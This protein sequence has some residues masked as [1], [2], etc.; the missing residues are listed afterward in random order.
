MD[1]SE[2]VRTASYHSL[3]LGK[4]RGCRWTG[5]KEAVTGRT[6]D[7]TFDLRGRRSTLYHPANIQGSQFVGNVL[8]LLK[9]LLFRFNG[10]IALRRKL[11]LKQ[12]QCK[13]TAALDNLYW[14]GIFPPLAVFR[15]W[16]VLVLYF[17]GTI[18]SPIQLRLA[19][20][21]I[22]ASIFMMYYWAMTMAQSLPDEGTAAKKFEVEESIKV[23]VGPV[24]RARAKHL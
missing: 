11:V 5:R 18:P 1:D 4:V 3:D 12:V 6:I 9:D 10:L 21:S 16:V 17:V 2:L 20:E 22:R 15:T 24:T 19:P 23:P 14:I 7:L 8:K 13:Q